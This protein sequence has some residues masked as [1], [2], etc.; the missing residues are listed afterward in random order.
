MT[1]NKLV[2]E[3]AEAAPPQLTVTSK[4]EHIAPIQVEDYLY[5]KSCLTSPDSV[6]KV[7]I[8]SP[9]M[10]HF[11]QLREVSSAGTAPD[12]SIDPGGGRAA[13]DIS[14]YKDMD[15][16]FEDLAEVYRTEIA[17]LAKAGVR[18]NPTPTWRRS[19]TGLSDQCF[20]VLTVYFHPARRH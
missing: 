14:T 6:V 15:A 16:F 17:A 9:T 2:G 3:K 11:R 19:R 4:L 13:I 18:R 20:P 1:K 8:P 7:A 12:P 10:V 5:V